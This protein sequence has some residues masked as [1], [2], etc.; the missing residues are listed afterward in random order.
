ML[1]L[2]VKVV[3]KLIILR[4]M[5]VTITNISVIFFRQFVG[6]MMSQKLFHSIEMLSLYIMACYVLPVIILVN[7]ASNWHIIEI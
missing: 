5:H 3:I 4:R 7:S 6:Q 2:N 1:Q